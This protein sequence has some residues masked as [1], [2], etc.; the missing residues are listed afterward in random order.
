MDT[1]ET[2]TDGSFSDRMRDGVVENAGPVVR[3]S[4]GR[5]ARF[6]RNGVRERKQASWGL[7]L[8]RCISIH[9]RLAWQWRTWRQRARWAVFLGYRGACGLRRTQRPKH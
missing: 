2:E 4:P 6:W 7:G 5:S 3:Y 8:R 1:G 9:H